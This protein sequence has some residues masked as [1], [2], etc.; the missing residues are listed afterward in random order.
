MAGSM[1]GF[2]RLFHLLEGSEEGSQA[3][4]DVLLPY[5][6]QALEMMS[7]LQAYVSLD[8]MAWR[9]SQ[10]DLCSGEDHKYYSCLEHLY[11]LSRVSDLLIL[12]FQPVREPGAEYVWPWAPNIQ[13]EE[14]SEWLRSLGMREIGQET[15]HPFYHEIVEVEQASDPDE[16]ITLLET[17]WPGFML[18]QMMFCRAGVR[19]RAGAHVARKDIAER[20]RLYWAYARNNRPP[21]DLSHGW[22]HNSQW[23]T[24]FRRDYVA[25]DAYYYN[26]DGEA[27]V[28]EGGYYLDIYGR[29]DTKADADE[30]YNTLPVRMELLTH[31]CLI[32]T[33]ERASEEGPYHLT[34]REPK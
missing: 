9:R 16:P 21:H 3:Y 11:A 20:S 10:P 8:A 19:I 2:R 25:E 13:L 22:G 28:H 7:V 23:G 33:P 26:V 17:I 34:Y 4:R 31:R 29:V 5:Q 15:F 1:P 24:D 32:I 14:R 30:P 6:P 18:G 12:P 27:E